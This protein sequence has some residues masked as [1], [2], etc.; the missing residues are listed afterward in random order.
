VYRRILG[1]IYDNEK[2]NWRIL[3]DKEIYASVKKT[4][5]KRDSKVKEIRC[6]FDRASSILCGNK[7]PTRCNR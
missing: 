6:G 5:Y 4:Y 3:T 2:A 1:P 7:M